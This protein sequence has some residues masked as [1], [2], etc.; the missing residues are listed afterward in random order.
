MLAFLPVARVSI[1]LGTGFAPSFLWLGLASPFP[2]GNLSLPSCCGGFTIPSG[3][4]RGSSF[5]ALGLAL[6]SWSSVWSVILTVGGWPFRLVVGGLAPARLPHDGDW[7]FLLTVGVD[8][9]ECLQ[10]YHARRIQ[11]E[12]SRIQGGWGRKEGGASKHRKNVLVGSSHTL[13]RGDAGGRRG[14]S[15]THPAGYP[16][17]GGEE[18]GE[19]EEKGTKRVGVRAWGCWVFG[20]GVLGGRWAVGVVNARCALFVE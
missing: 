17:G 2:S 8:I 11:R 4:G 13:T 20:R 5:L 10:W 16:S 3:D 7:P 1:L 12:K 6:L 19:G 15:S 14:R 18:E 9:R